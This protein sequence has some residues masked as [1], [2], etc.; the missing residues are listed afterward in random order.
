MLFKTEN[1]KEENHLGVTCKT[2]ED[3]IKI[4]IF[5][6]GGLVVFML[7]NGSKARGFKPGRKRQIF[8][9]DNNS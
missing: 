3:N 4:H 8:K 1:L 7:P 9:G 2:L 5:A 6:L